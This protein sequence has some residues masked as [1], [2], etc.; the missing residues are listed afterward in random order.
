MSA[1]EEITITRDLWGLLVRWDD[2]INATVSRR[3]SWTA[4][5]ADG[6]SAEHLRVAVFRLAA[7]VVGCA[8]ACAHA[9]LGGT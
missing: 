3:W 8:A 1:D 7:D 6:A 4:G 2:G 9:T 5:D